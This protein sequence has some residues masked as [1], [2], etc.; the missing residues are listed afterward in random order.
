M[1]VFY[2]VKPTQVQSIFV[3]AARRRG[4]RTR[5]MAEQVR[6]RGSSD[7]MW[8]RWSARF[9]ALAAMLAVESIPFAAARKPERFVDPIDQFLAAQ[10]T[11]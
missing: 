8:C 4:A 3:A 7:S 11:P 1:V 5:Y 6:G 9:A 2:R 10:K